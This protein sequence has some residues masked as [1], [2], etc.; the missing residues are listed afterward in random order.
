[1][2]PDCVCGPL[3]AGGC[4]EEH[5]IVPALSDRPDARASVRQPGP[6][7]RQCHRERTSTVAKR[8]QPVQQVERLPLRF[9]NLKRSNIS[10]YKEIHQPLI[11]GLF[12][13]SR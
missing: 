6:V 11:M 3:L 7:V 8:T 13:Q 1:M 5:A 4:G 10:Q 12:R 2:Q 9:E